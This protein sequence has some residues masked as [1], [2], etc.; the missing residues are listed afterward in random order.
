MKKPAKSFEIALSAIACAVAAVSLTVGSYVDVLLATGY[1]LAVFALMVPLSKEFVWGAALAFL[2]AV[3]LSFMF[4]GFSVIK[5]L[6]FLAFFGLH[7]IANFL[8]K[9]FVKNKWLYLPVFLVKALWFDAAMLLC[10]FVLLPVMGGSEHSWYPYAEQYLYLIVFLGGTL[11]FAA[12]DFMMFL[13][14]KS[15]NKIVFRIR[16]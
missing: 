6:P 16:R 2:G 10:W 4:C 11:F 7:P 12:Y 14:Q 8:Q 13:C 3:L 1:I 15:V 9:K 5:L